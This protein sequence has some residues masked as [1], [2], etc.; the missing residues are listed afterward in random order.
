MTTEVPSFAFSNELC[1]IQIRLICFSSSQCPQML[2]LKKSFNPLLHMTWTQR[3]TRLRIKSVLS[4][5]Q[6]EAV[7]TIEASVGYHALVWAKKLE[8]LKD[9][10]RDANSFQ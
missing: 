10:R 5:Y 1:A 9:L 2:A 8:A 6:R 3:I 7:G 4:S